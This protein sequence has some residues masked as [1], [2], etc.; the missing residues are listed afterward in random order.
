MAT[1]LNT[2]ICASGATPA[3]LGSGNS[4]NLGFFFPNNTAQ[5]PPHITKG[6]EVSGDLETNNLMEN[7]NKSKEIETVDHATEVA[8]PDMQRFIDSLKRCI[9]TNTLAFEIGFKNLG[10]RLKSG[11][12]IL[13][14]ISGTV[15]PAF[16]L[17]VMGVSGVGKSTFIRLLMG[18]MKNTSGVIYING[19][20]KSM[21]DT[22]PPAPSWTETEIQSHV[23]D[24]LSC[25]GL[26][27]IQKSLVGD[28]IKPMISGGQ[29]KRVSIGIELAA[30]PIALVLD[31][32][33]S[34]L[35]AT[36]ALSII[37]MLK[38]LCRL[39]ITVVCI[40]HQPRVEI[41]QSLDL[42]LLLADG[43]EIYSAKASDATE[44]FINAGFDIPNHCNPA[45]NVQIIADDSIEHLELLDALSK[46][47]SARGLAAAAPGVKT[48][49]EE[50][51][52]MTLTP[53]RSGL[54]IRSIKL[55][56]TWVIQYQAYLVKK[57]DALSIMAIHMSD[58]GVLLMCTM[59]CD[60]TVCFISTWSWG[61][62]SSPP[63]F[64]PLTGLDDYCA[65]SSY[66][67]LHTLKGQVGPNY[68]GKLALRH[69]VNANFQPGSL[70]IDFFPILQKL[71]VS[72]Q[73]WLKLA[74][75]L[76]VRELKLHRSS[77]R[78]L[79]KQVAAESAPACFGTML[80]H[81]QLEESIPDDRACDILAMLVGAEL[82]T[83]VGPNRLPNW[84]DES[85]L[86]YIRAIIEEVHRWA[87]IGSL[88]IPHAS[89]KDDNYNGQHIPESTIIFPNLTALSRHPDRYRNPDLFE[90][91]IFLGDELDASASALHANYIK[92]DH[93]H[94]GFGRRLLL[95][96][97][98]IKAIEG[99]TL[100]MDA[101]IKGLVTKPEPYRVS[102]TSRGDQF[103]QVIEGSMQSA[104]TD[105]LNFDD[106]EFTEE[107]TLSGRV[108]DITQ[109]QD[110]L[111]DP[112]RQQRKG[113]WPFSTKDNGYIVSDCAAE[114]MKAVLLLQEECNLPKLI[115]PSR[116][117]DCVDT[118]LTMQNPDGGFGSYE[119]ARGPAAMELLNPAEVFD[120]IM[121]EYSYPECSTAVLTSLSLFRKH[122]PKYRSQDIQFTIDKVEKYIIKAQFKD[123]SCRNDERVR[124][125]C[126]FLVDKQMEDG[127]WGEKY[128]A[129]EKVEWVNH[130]KSQVV[131]TA[132]AVL[133][134]MSA[135]W[136]GKRVVERGLDLLRSRQLATGEWLQEGIE[137][138]FNRTCMIGY[139]NYKFYFPIRALGRYNHDYLPY[140][141]KW[142]LFEDM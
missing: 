83:V 9:G 131:N 71:P 25:L 28:A 38:A 103:G 139:P 14:D 39:G 92:R 80:V 30:A 6:H 129:C 73:P 81:V 7:R 84:D 65:A 87:P 138:V 111:E 137:G 96:G 56:L 120:R 55:V 36:S 68:I 15:K 78:T 54:V 128:E 76:R 98:A 132:W 116:L 115:S 2:P 135:R 18:K 141:T 97:F 79:K 75:S 17:A 53:P 102:I 140:M 35:D 26:S 85:S 21:S 16:L 123:G 106:V 104:K 43:Q 105:I 101:K 72:M 27:H 127:G 32:P 51:T 121:V 133:A 108:E 23:D 48:F 22:N 113:G 66:F 41:F 95:W 42:L 52:S 118:L 5:N 126:E 37:N 69:V 24:L 93:F 19:V 34:G 109:F 110:N 130:E 47:A 40:L 107:I 63:P 59:Q 99:E 29:R 114:G 33:T 13:Q 136:P 74:Q 4:C 10:L 89:T 112:Y 122:Y 125:A 1:S 100:D 44:Y 61:P 20:A 64:F 11:K 90:P 124:K 62:R 91:E 45:D 82:D 46:S 67:S 57:P 117:Q 70:L 119:R 77:L 88:G 86:P 3:F 8:P 49:G 94:Y 60:M 50:N 58:V 12:P 31:E 142:D 134:L